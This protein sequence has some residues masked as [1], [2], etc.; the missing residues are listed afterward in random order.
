MNVLR[1]ISVI[2]LA[3]EA[4]IFALI[5]LALFGAL[6]YGVWRLRQHRNM[7]TWLGDIRRYVMLGLSTV[8]QAMDAAAKPVIAVHAAFATV[9]GWLD[10][11]RKREP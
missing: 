9:E 2:L 1:D 3:A 8:E 5:P 7:P 10:A 6:V 4:F 11:L